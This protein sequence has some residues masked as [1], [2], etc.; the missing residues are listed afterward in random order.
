MEP[1]SSSPF[2]LELDGF[3]Y[4]VRQTN[5]ICYILSY[6]LVCIFILKAFLAVPF[7][8]VDLPIP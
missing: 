4:P 2:S 7:F 6:L 5:A 1:E 3:S 8:Q